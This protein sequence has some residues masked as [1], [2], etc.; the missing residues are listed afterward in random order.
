MTLQ[1]TT[2]PRRS[3]HPVLVIVP[4]ALSALRLIIAIA[5]A[6]LPNEW[7]LIAVITA[8][9]SDLLDGLLARSLG[10]CS[11]AGGLLDAIADKCFVLTVLTVF[12]L[13]G[14][15]TVWETVLLVQ[16][17]FCVL[18]AVVH[19]LLLHRWDA[20]RKMPPRLAGKL[21]TA[22]LFALFVLLCVTPHPNAWTVAFI[23]ITGAMST[24]AGFDYAEQ[25]ARSLH[26]INRT[27]P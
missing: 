14:Q 23:Y 6:F 16:R 13:G 5:F 20:M 3:R 21:T 17:D 1:T 7:R 8:G 4:N 19:A 27:N 9:L 10:V 18:M 11:W 25:L 2:T 26:C 22:C 24:L 15:L 12:A